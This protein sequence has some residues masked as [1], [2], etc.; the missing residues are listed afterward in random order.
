MITC[1]LN[2]RLKGIS[3]QISRAVSLH[4]PSSLGFCPTNASRLDLPKLLSLSPQL[5]DTA[6][7]SLRFLSP[8]SVSWKLP[9][10]SKLGTIA[11][12]TSS[13]FPLRECLVF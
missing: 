2:Q 7:L 3:L 4:D 8:C 13:V 5:S 9:L 1:K 10:G 12:L 11:G 6:G